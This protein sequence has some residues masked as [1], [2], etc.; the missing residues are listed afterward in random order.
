MSTVNEKSEH[1]YLNLWLQSVFHHCE[2]TE[3]EE[4]VGCS[5]KVGHS[6]PSQY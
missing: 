6:S 1:Y 3:Q 5:R 2:W 4:S